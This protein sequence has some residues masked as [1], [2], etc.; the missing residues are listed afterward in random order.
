MDETKG[1]L[2]DSPE[3][4]AAI[5]S[6]V[7]LIAG[8]QDEIAL[9]RF[10]ASFGFSVWSSGSYNRAIQALKRAKPEI[11]VLDLDAVRH[12]GP[13]VIREIS[14]HDRCGLIVL[15]SLGGLSDRVLGLELGADEYLSKPFEPRELVARIKSL[16]RRM[17]TSAADRLE[18]SGQATFGDWTYCTAT[19]E[20]KHA[21]GRVEPLTA[22]E[23]D[24]LVSL[25]RRPNR[26]LSREQLQRDEDCADDPAFERSFDVR[27]SRIRKKLECDP[28]SPRYIKTVYGA[29]Y[30]FSASVTWH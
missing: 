5:R 4:S 16:S 12:D 2:A 20:L 9:R 28:R 21:D 13:T 25:L 17:T 15:S 18:P 6:R 3:T 27:I 14:Q 29:G 8:P 11:I 7:W 24:L 1:E 23:G 26:L 30:I 22:A 19:L 10:V